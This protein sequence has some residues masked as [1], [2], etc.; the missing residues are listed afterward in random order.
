MPCCCF[1]FSLK[2]PEARLQ[3]G[4]ADGAGVAEVLCMCVY[5]CACE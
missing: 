3:V 1:C 4:V 5:M 2:G